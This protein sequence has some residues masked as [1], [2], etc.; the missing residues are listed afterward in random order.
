MPEHGPK[1]SQAMREAILERDNYECQGCRIFEGC[2]RRE[3]HRIPARI[4]ERE[5]RGGILQ[6]HHILPQSFSDRP[7]IG[8]NPNFPENMLTLCKPAHIGETGVHPDT[9]EAMLQY[10]Q[11]NKQA[12]KE[13]SQ[14]RSALLDQRQIYWDDSHDRQ[15]QV[16]AIRNT[17]RAKRDGWVWRWE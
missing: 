9:Y 17:Q 12:Y 4:D 16:M 11:G 15:L 8:I 6:V 13:M 14:A 1:Y 10:R 2:D 5:A 3:P 7:A